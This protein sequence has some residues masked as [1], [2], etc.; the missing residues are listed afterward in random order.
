MS[1]A[2]EI[3]IESAI[4]DFSHI[5]KIER[6]KKKLSLEQIAEQLKLPVKR[7]EELESGQLD[8][9]ISNAFYKGYLRSYA[10]VLKLEHQ[11]LMGDFEGHFSSEAQIVSTHRISDFN[12]SKRRE[13]ST[14]TYWF[15]WLSGLV[16]LL[17]VIVVGWGFK[18]KLK[19]TSWGNEPSQENVQQ[20]NTIDLSL[21]STQIIQT[22]DQS[23]QVESSLASN[24]LSVDEFEKEPLAAVDAETELNAN[25]PEEPIVS[26]SP[27]QPIS[28]TS[29][30]FATNE[31]QSL[32]SG[33]SSE[34]VFTFSGDCWVN[35]VDATGERV[36]YGVK[37]AGRIM[38]INVVLP[39]DITLGEP[40]VVSL[41]ANQK[42]IDLSGYRAGRSAN[43]SI[44]ENL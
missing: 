23:L 41:T 14:K 42:N 44:N 19:S 10:G 26:S 40:S 31:T 11:A 22:E 32:V 17:L 15:K 24:D 29:N 43:F 7:L 34:L 16:A 3:N 39:V 1:Q 21:N 4:P 18:E 36:A 35:V 25:V 12:S 20:A 30:S 2:E 8:N 37:T 28:N 27:Q 5:L 9:S 38:T 13:V 6:E 33:E